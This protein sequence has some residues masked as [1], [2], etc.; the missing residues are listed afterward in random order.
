RKAID[1]VKEIRSA[2]PQPASRFAGVAIPDASSIPADAIDKILGVKGQVNAGMYKALIGRKATMHGKTVGNQMG[3]NTWAAFAGSEESALV[4]G[5]FAMTADEILPVLKALRAANINVVAI[6]NHMTH[7]DPQYVFLHYWGKGNAITLAKGLRAALDAQQAK[8]QAASIVFVCE[9]GAARSVIAASYFNK[10][11][12]ERGLT[13][14][15]SSRGTDPDPAFGAKV[16]AG[17]KADGL[18]EPI[19]IPKLI[20][21]SDLANA[22][23]VIT[24]GVEVPAGL[25]TVTRQQ[26][27]GVPAPS[28]DYAIARTDIAR[29]VEALIAELAGQ[30]KH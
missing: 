25:P 20:A 9:H 21:A 15:A 23:Q 7:E 18:P 26:W 8:A 29:R 30:H 10:L 12:A 6:H 5:D 22:E 19:G 14:R 13:Q 4:D 24:F 3:V 11:A 1:K 2:N 28:A 17:L 27:N 16:L